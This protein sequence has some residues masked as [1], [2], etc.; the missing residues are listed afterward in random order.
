M[1]SVLAELEADGIARPRSM[2]GWVDVIGRA[3]DI[4]V[5]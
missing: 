4:I 2:S 1:D 3:G 5:G